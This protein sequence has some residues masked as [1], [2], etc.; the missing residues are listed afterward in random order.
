M[1]EEKEREISEHV[2]P[3]ADSYKARKQVVEDHIKLLE[4]KNDLAQKEIAHVDGMLE[5]F[6]VVARHNIGFIQMLQK[7]LQEE[8]IEQGEF[9]IANKW[10]SE[11]SK[12][13]AE[14]INT[15][16]EEKTKRHGIVGGNQGLINHL[17]SELDVYE[18]QIRK[19]ETLGKNAKDLEE[20]KEKAPI[21]E[22]KKPP[23]SK[24]KKRKTA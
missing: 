24:K 9:D 12:I 19:I 23:K 4:E 22:I 3:Q 1:S 14:L 6:K 21:S 16:N 7:K 10:I 13:P 8:E 18:G 11:I 17:K 5:A 20:R 15:Y 2:Q